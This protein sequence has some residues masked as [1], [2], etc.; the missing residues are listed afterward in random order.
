MLFVSK[1]IAMFN[2]CSKS[3]AAQISPNVCLRALLEELFACFPKFCFEYFV[4]TEDRVNVLF[5]HDVRRCCW[6][7]RAGSVQN[8]DFAR[9]GWINTY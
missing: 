4:S 6:Q 7:L 2:A 8:S 1:D 9:W 3:K 5:L